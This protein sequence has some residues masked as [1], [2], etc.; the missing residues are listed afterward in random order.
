MLNKKRLQI[1]FPAILLLIGIGASSAIIVLRPRIIATPTLKTEAPLVSVIQVEPQMVRLNVHSQGIVRP[2]NEIDLISEVAGKI[3]YLHPDFAAGGFFNHNDLLVSIDPSDYDYAIA[4]AHAQI[5]EAKRQLAMEEAQADQARNEWQSLGDGAPSGLVMR[6]PQLA[7]ARAKL[8]AAQ[9]GLIQARIKRSRCELR[10]PFAGRLLSKNIGL[11][12]FIQAGEKLA[13]IYSTDT[14]EIR[15]PLPTDQLAFLDI[16]LLGRNDSSHQEQTKV[17]LTAQ[18]TGAMQTWEGRIVRTEGA[19]D[20]TTGVLYAV[21]EI[22]SPYRTKGYRPPLISGL[23]VQ[24]E[25]EGKEMPNVY[26]LPQIAMNAAQEVL[27]VDAGQKLHIRRLEVLRNEPD[28][29]L[30]KEGLKM[31]DRIV[32]SGIQ[33]PIEGMSVRIGENPNR[34][35]PKPDKP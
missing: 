10:A 5:S 16:P 17:S 29:I 7:E 26:V 24:A 30:V 14:A 2:R 15:L 35:H 6:E 13:R 20:N 19:L 1:I 27:L 9:A 4:Q 3:I 8:K 18:F 25:I 28:R 21:A 11:G 22:L 12:Q 31:G 32:I 34:G 33:V 23:F